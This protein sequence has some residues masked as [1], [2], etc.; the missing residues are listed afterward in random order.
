VLDLGDAGG[1][2]PVERVP[3]VPQEVP[4]AARERVALPA[5]RAE[6]LRVDVP[7]PPVDL[8]RHVQRREGEVDAVRPERVVEH[9]ATDPRVAEQPDQ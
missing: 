4:A 6:P 9:P 7:R 2:L 8:D 3:G 5:I 1:G